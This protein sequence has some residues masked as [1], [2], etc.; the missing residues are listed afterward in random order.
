MIGSVAFKLGQGDNV[1]LARIGRERES[2]REQ[3]FY[4]LSTE[5]A[6]L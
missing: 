4:E 3:V 2:E 1:D 6:P 5:Q